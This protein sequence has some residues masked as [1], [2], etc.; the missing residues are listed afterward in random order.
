MRVQNT[1]STAIDNIFIDV[2][3][4]ESY[5]ITPIVNGVSDHEVQLLTI[6]TDYSYIPTHR[7]KTVRK[8]N[9]YT[10]LERSLF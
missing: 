8:I 10:K 6:S 5:M 1:S 7:S 2:S 4:F 9:K 3:Q